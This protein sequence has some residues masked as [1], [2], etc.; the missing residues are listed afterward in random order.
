MQNRL[1]KWYCHEKMKH[2]PSWGTKHIHHCWLQQNLRWHVEIHL[3]PFFH[4]SNEQKVNEWATS[5][6]HIWWKVNRFLVSLKKKVHGFPKELT[7][8]YLLFI[9]KTKYT[10][11]VT[12]GPQPSTA[13]VE[14]ALV[15]NAGIPIYPERRAGVAWTIIVS[16]G[17]TL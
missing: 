5:D 8:L 9:R 4:A 17:K 15:R 3:M 7:E 13:Q 2:Y 12:N 10:T 14:I 6:C 1:V 11:K 16:R